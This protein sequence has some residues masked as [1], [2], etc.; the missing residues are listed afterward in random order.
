MFRVRFLML[1][2][3]GA[4]SIGLA[5]S[6]K[7]LDR[8]HRQRTEMSQ[9]VLEG[10]ERS[11]QEALPAIEKR[12]KDKRLPSADAKDKRLSSA[13]AEEAA[14]WS[15]V[16]L[17][18]GPERSQFSAQQPL[19]VND[20]VIL[21]TKLG[22]LVLNSDPTGV[23]VYID[24]VRF[25][26]PTNTAVWRKEGSCMVRFSKGMASVGGVC[27]IKEMELTTATATFSPLQF[28]CK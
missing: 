9:D 24:D 17:R 25:D 19:A 27:E 14:E 13:D 5:E 11:V 21:T 22:K 10:D 7:A 16:L 20:I 3:C 6:N 18:T 8:I 1:T 2:V 15:W 26:K 28:N 4:V 12:F 23:S